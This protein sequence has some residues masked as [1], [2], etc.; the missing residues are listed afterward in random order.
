MRA[1]MIEDELYLSEESEAR[2]QHERYQCSDI[3]ISYSL[4]SS[5]SILAVND[6]HHQATVNDI[7]L[8]GLSIGLQQSLTVGDLLSIEIQSSGSLENEV[9]TAEI[10]WCKSVKGNQ[11]NAGL[12]VISADSHTDNSANDADLHNANQNQLICPSCNEVSFYLKEINSD[13]N[14]PQ[15]HHCCRC[16]HSHQITDVMAFN[17]Q[18]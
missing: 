15:L 1:L 8:S 6:S 13:S 7:S 9:L 14:K 18:L 4:F 16:G 12:H 10:M 11:Y 2:R 17:R 5:H 3:K